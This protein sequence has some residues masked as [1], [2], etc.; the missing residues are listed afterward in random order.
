MEIDLHE[1]PREGSTVADS[2]S[3]E[4]VSTPE[5]WTGP[6]PSSQE[7]HRSNLDV[8]IAI[9]LVTGSSAGKVWS[10]S[11]RRDLPGLGSI[12]GSFIISKPD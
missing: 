12:K 6:A 3:I 11:M 4:Q 5:E 10:L 7:L 1:A 9:V 8:A 2:K